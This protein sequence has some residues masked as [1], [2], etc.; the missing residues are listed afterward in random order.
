MLKGYIKYVKVTINLIP[1]QE[2]V[3][4]IANTIWCKMESSRN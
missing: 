1:N 2:G 4:E 3:N